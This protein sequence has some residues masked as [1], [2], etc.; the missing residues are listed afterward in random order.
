MYDQAESFL[1]DSN[2][3][4]NWFLAFLDQCQ[5]YVVET[6]EF[7]MFGWCPDIEPVEQWEENYS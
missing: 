5:R 4:L 1:K 6:E 7:V 3:S 2:R